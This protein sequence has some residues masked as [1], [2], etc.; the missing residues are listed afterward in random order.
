MI[1][2]LSAAK[3]ASYIAAIDVSELFTKIASL[4]NVFQRFGLANTVIHQNN[5]LV[6]NFLLDMSHKSLLINQ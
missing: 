5:A 3:K 2:A 6:A 1:T 4:Q